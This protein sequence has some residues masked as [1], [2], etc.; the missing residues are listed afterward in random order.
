MPGR[1]QSAPL[2]YG[3]STGQADGGLADIPPSVSIEQDS[4]AIVTSRLDCVSMVPLPT[5][6]LSF[7]ETGVILEYTGARTGA[8][9]RKTY[10]AQALSASCL[11]REYPCDLCC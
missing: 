1:E 8:A 4:A 9:V 3:E 6:H 7:R 5:L 2:R 11:S 10:R